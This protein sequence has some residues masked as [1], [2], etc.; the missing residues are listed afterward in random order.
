MDFHLP[1]CS[2]ASKFCPAAASSICES[3]R[4]SR[5]AERRA[6][7]SRCT[8]SRMKLRLETEGPVM[9]KKLRLSRSLHNMSVCIYIYSCIYIYVCVCTY[10][11]SIYIYM[12]DVCIFVYVR[13]FHLVRIS[14]ANICVYTHMY[15]YIYIYIYIYT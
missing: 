14:H 10:Y 1:S 8:A 4:K 7:Q 11:V 13:S 15:I 9:G 3:Q 2:R 6:R 12:H 5:G